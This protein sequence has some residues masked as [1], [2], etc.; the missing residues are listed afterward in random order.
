MF[1]EVNL[2]STLVEAHDVEL[3]G[4]GFAASSLETVIQEIFYSQLNSGHFHRWA[5]DQNMPETSITI[6]CV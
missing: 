3:E 1:A 2:V 5:I 4:S 6:K